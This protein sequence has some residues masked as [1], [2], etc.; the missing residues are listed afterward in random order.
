MDYYLTIKEKNE[1][2]AGLKGKHESIRT[3]VEFF[4]A[5][6]KISGIK[7]IRTV[8]RVGLREAKNFADEYFEDTE[9]LVRHIKGSFGA[10]LIN[11]QQTSTTD[12]KALKTAISRELRRRGKKNA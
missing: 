7:E 8:T 11:V 9:K 10:D 4:K 12:L 2:L 3:I 5:N 6:K 1:I